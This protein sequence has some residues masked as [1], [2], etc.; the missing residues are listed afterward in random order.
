MGIMSVLQIQLCSE[1]PVGY[2]GCSRCTTLPSS[3][4]LNSFLKNNLWNILNRTD[5]LHV[6][7]DIFVKCGCSL[8]SSFDSFSH[9]M[10]S[11]HPLG[12]IYLFHLA[13]L[14]VKALL[15]F[16]CELDLPGWLIL[17]PAV[18]QPS[19]ALTAGDS[20]AHHFRQQW[21]QQSTHA[22]CR[23]RNINMLML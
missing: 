3:E 20:S 8:S 4:I 22:S 14:Y 11:I 17:D 16:I 9:L 15:I 21:Q 1:S 5:S 13:F 6:P 19:F 10:C 23:Y 7:S 2:A 12:A 18:C